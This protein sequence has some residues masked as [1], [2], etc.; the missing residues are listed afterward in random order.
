MTDQTTG[1]THL[2]ASARALGVAELLQ[3]HSIPPSV[4]VMAR[5]ARV[6]RQTMQNA[7]YKTQIAGLRADLLEARRQGAWWEEQAR[8]LAGPM[9]KR[10][11][12]NIDRLY[13]RLTYVH[14]VNC[15]SVSWLR[16]AEV[17]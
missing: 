13:D 17:A 2:S 4:A 5:L 8:I 14:F 11:S 16:G 6:C 7:H 9:P 3:P 15:R 1:R 12:M 10:D